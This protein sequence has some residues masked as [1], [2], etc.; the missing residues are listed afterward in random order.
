MNVLIKKVL[1]FVLM[2]FIGMNQLNAQITITGRITDI[3]KK[4][5][6]F[7]N[8]YITKP[9]DTISI[10]SGTISD[11]NGDF[12]LEI[13]IKEDKLILFVSSMGYKLF[14]KEID[15]DSSFPIAIQLSQDANVLETVEIIGKRKIVKNDVDKKEYI[16]TKGDRKK[17]ITS[18]SLLHTIPTL[19]IDET[20]NTI[21]TMQGNSVKILIN[22]VNA[23]EIELM[24]IET[25]DIIKIEHY[26]ILPIRYQD[27]GYSEVVN[28]ITKKKIQGGS[29]MANLQN[30]LIT[31][32]GN[33]TVSLNYNKKQSQYGF[34]YYYSFRDYKKKSIDEYLLYNTLNGF[35]EKKI[36]GINSPYGYGM[37]KINLN[38]SNQRENNYLFSI[39]IKPTI[40]SVFDK[41]KYN[42]LRTDNDSI[43]TGIGNM[44]YNRKEINNSIDVYYQ[45]TISVNSEII[46]N[47]LGNFFDNNSK[48]KLKEYSD[49]Y[50]TLINN[51]SNTDA[52]KSSLISELL[53]TKKIGKYNFST[54]IK[55][56]FGEL[57]Q[58]IS[59]NFGNGNYVLRK[60]DKYIYTSLM[61]KLKKV[62]FQGSFGFQS[63]SFE[64][65]LFSN[66]YVFNTFTASLNTSVSLS[67]KSSISFSYKKTNK[68]PSLVQLSN[69][70]GYDDNY[71][72]FIGN[73][74]LK[75]YNVHDTSIDFN[76][77]G[78]KVLFGMKLQYSYSPKPILIKYVQ[79]ENHLTRT[80]NNEKDKNEVLLS[81][82]LNFKMLK[83]KMNITL[84]GAGYKLIN[85]YENGTTNKLL[86]FYYSLMFNY[87][88]KNIV[89]KG[90]IDNPI[91][92][93]NG[94]QTTTNPINS[95]I[96]LYYK[97][98]KITLGLGLY[99][100]LNKSSKT[101]IDIYNPFIISKYTNQ[102]FDN[103]K[104]FYLRAVYNLA[105]GKQMRINKKLHNKDED[106][107]YLEH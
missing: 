64:E 91:K 55:Y 6:V 72:I 60:S 32:Y 50:A 49:S 45:K 61:T 53:Y 78:N 105:F 26:D 107:G 44:S 30:A 88:H 52:F 89:I 57:N 71:I 27:S 87:N 82:Y 28:I 86:A 13:P 66:N 18:L 16:I 96:S 37:H 103:G 62:S 77:F 39:K 98:N 83:K 79:N 95:D 65:N 34:Y 69:Y 81:S 51:F 4:P 90:S 92:S 70:Q 63:N 41:P 68:N 9:N 17:A 2:L 97:F 20:N 73:P 5:I 54:G 1:I 94:L 3:S 93:I 33:H 29:V 59:N 23:G 47:V 46:V 38:Y 25:T 35:H 42:L 102:I 43:T 104:M 58:K 36:A 67:K 31:G 101:I 12:T 40:I 15:F 11:F 99:L 10:I 21:K 80:F 84:Y 76:Y 14:K 7:A 56:S 106:K 19:K 48:Y 75:P 74:N 24:T 100:P 22:G 8:I 85:K